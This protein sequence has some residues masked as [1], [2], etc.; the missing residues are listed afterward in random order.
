[1]PPDGT[2][3]KVIIP[4]PVA[5][6]TNTIELCDELLLILLLL[7]QVSSCIVVGSGI[8]PITNTTTHNAI[9]T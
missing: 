7:L 4:F 3:I 1:L 9:K 8:K 2:G 6:G 5:N